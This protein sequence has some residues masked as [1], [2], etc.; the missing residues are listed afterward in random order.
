LIVENPALVS[1]PAA[2]ETTT[3]LYYDPGKRR[4]RRGAGSKGPGG[5][6]RLLQVLQQFDCTYDLAMMRTQDLMT[7]L[8]PEFNRYRE[9]SLFDGAATIQ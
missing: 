1:C 6:R 2:V 7:K 4:V 3:R 8:P 9:A 5:C